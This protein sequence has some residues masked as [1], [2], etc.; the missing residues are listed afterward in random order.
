MSYCR[1]MNPKIVKRTRLILRERPRCRSMILRLQLRPHL[2]AQGLWDRRAISGEV[3]SLSEGMRIQVKKMILEG[4]WP[5]IGPRNVWMKWRHPKKVREKRELA[6]VNTMPSGT[7]EIK[8]GE[9]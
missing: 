9:E 7:I 5:E 1:T 6:P 3:I 2:N 8:H 4:C